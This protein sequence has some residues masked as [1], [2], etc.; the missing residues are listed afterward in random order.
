MVMK[1]I[2]AKEK[3]NLSNIYLYINEENNLCYSYDFSAYMLI[4]LLNTELKKGKMKNTFFYNLSIQEVIE[5][6]SG[7]ETKVGDDRITVTMDNLPRCFQWKSE[8]SALK[9]T[10][11]RFYMKFIL[12]IRSMFCK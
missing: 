9:N 10:H 4:K 11:R 12:Y 7:L 5:R 6:F 2:L 1:N 8:F 3:H